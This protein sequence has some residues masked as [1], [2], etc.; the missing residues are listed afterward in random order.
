MF[1]NDKAAGV[2]SILDTNIASHTRTHTRPPNKFSNVT[3]SIKNVLLL[4]YLQSWRDQRGWMARGGHSH[5]SCQSL[6]IHLA[7]LHACN[8]HFL[9]S[10]AY[11]YVRV[12][13][14]KKSRKQSGSKWATQKTKSLKRQHF[15]NL[16]WD[17]T[18]T[19]NTT[20][21]KS[22]KSLRSNSLTLPRPPRIQ[23]KEWFATWRSLE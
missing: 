23:W 13:V 4:S 3:V 14:G 11:I 22:I 16:V 17:I 21:K 18:A 15:L 5:G 1:G 9:Q 7:C 19:T 12:C 8:G 6:G 2:S 10:V 20:I